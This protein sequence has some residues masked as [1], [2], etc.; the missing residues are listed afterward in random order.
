MMAILLY[1]NHVIAAWTHTDVAVFR[2]SDVGVRRGKRVVTC[3][4]SWK[5]VSFRKHAA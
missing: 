2:G 1:L 5:H 4:R 3:I